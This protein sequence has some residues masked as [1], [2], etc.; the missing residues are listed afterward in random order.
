[1]RS[2]SHKYASRK[3][4]GIRSLVV[5]LAVM[6][7]ADCPRRKLMYRFVTAVV[8]VSLALTVAA[9]NVVITPQKHAASAAQPGTAFKAD[10]KLV[11]IPVSVTDRNGGTVNGLGVGNF[12]VSE[13]DAPRPIVSFSS[14][15][16]PCSV[17]IVF[18]SSASMKN[19][20][21]KSKMALRE[22]LDTANPLDEAFLMTFANKPTLRIDFTQD[23][24]AIQNSAVFERPAGSTALLDAVA[25]AL[26][27]LRSAHNARKALLVISDGGD[28]SS[29]YSQ[30]ELL[31]A[32]WEADAQIY[33]IGIPEYPR[34]L[35]ERAQEA[36]GLYVLQEL[37]KRTGGRHII[38]RDPGQLADAMAEIGRSMRNQYVIG[39]RPSEDAQAGKWQRIR[40]KV[41]IPERTG[42]FRVDS[43]T[44][45]YVPERQDWR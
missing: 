6:I 38:I 18:D 32:A 2:H 23:F 11:L 26:G 7:M 45:Y 42:Y 37:A 22:F 40:V 19:T 33:S 1:M 13:A 15:D 3:A 43:R 21:S 29:R 44:K 35:V 41:H 31:K 30:S 27:R 20:I 12:T 8:L 28:N 36:A 10:A 24:A 16:A 39:I 9:Q 14:E 5:F 17:G 25:D 34:S 4:T